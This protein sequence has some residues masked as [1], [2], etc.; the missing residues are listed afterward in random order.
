V[1]AV[2]QSNKVPSGQIA[3]ETSKS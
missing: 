3:S 2:V 1:A